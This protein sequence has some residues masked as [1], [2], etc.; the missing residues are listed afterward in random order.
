[1]VTFVETILWKGPVRGQVV[2]PG[3]AVYP[4]R[5]LELFA[6][7]ILETIMIRTIGEL[8]SKVAFRVFPSSVD[9]FLAALRVVAVA[10]RRKMRLEFVNE[11]MIIDP[12]ENSECSDWYELS[13]C[14]LQYIIIK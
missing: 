11:G 13:I 4:L 3:V 8:G 2:V 7:A 1:M 9:T 6:P 14:I 10:L 5:H 12:K